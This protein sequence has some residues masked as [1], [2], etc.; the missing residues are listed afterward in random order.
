M[1]TTTGTPGGSAVRRVLRAAGLLGGATAAAWCASVLLATPAQAASADADAP[2]LLG[3]VVERVEAPTRPVVAT[4]TR[5][6]RRATEPVAPTPAAPASTPAPVATPDPVATT[7]RHATQTVRRA[8]AE[9]RRS[10]AFLPV[11]RAT[12]EETV[13]VVGES[14][15]RVD[16]LGGQ[17]GSTSQRSLAPVTTAIGATVTVV[18]EL[19][20]ETVAA[21]ASSVEELVP[22]VEGAAPAQ[23]RVAS[24]RPGHREHGAHTPGARGGRTLP[25]RTDASAAPAGTDQVLAEHDTTSDAA[26]RVTDLGSYAGGAPAPAAPAA[27]G[28]AYLPGWPQLGLPT[29][30]GPVAHDGARPS[31]S[32]ALDPGCTPD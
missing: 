28:A 26:P 25:G 10:V 3:Q 1:R 12:V 21:T 16:R 7:T 30:P 31:S 18:R 23:P 22:A 13:P 19:V 15:D 17:L 24:A 6:V 5:V 2:D 8:H 9:V 20:G 14:L 29:C 27:A 32:P 11:A 4:A